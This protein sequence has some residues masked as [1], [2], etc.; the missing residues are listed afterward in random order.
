MPAGAAESAAADSRG[1]RPGPPAR[2]EDPSTAL[3]AGGAPTGGR[4]ARQQAGERRTLIVTIPRVSWSEL[5]EADMPNLHWLM[6]QGAVGLMPV[7]KPSDADPDRTWVTL[8]A[9]RAAVSSPDMGV[10]RPWDRGGMKIDIARLAEANRRAHT[11][12]VPSMMGEMI[13][14]FI[15]ATAVI[16]ADPASRASC[17]GLAVLADVRGG[18]DG[19]VVGGQLLSEG[20][21]G[22]ALDRRRV[23]AAVRDA[24]AHY[25]VILLDLSD[26][27]R[28]DAA[29]SPTANRP[30]SGPKSAALRATDA[31]IGDAV[32]A[33][34]GHRTLVAILSPVCPNYTRAFPP[35]NARLRDPEARTLGPMVLCEASRGGAISS[36]RESMADAPADLA[37]ISAKPGRS[38]LLTSA[39]TRCPGLVTAADLVPTLARWW[40]VY[41]IGGEPELRPSRGTLAGA[42]GGHALSVVPASDSLSRLD[43]LDRVLA[44]RYRLRVPM[45]KWYVAYALFVLAAGLGLAG[46]G[47]AWLRIGGAKVLGLAFVPVGLA[48]AAPVPP[49]HDAAYLIVAL[50]AA[51]AIALIA[52]GQETRSCPT[53]LAVAML[54][55]S[56]IIVSDVLAG[57]PLMRKSALEMGVMMGSRFYGIGNEYMGSLVGMTTI[58]LGALLQV[59]PQAGRVCALLGVFVA[60]AIGAP[61]WGANWGG[62]LT[63]AVGLATLWLLCLPRVRPRHLA[64]VAALLLASVALPPLLDLVRPAAERS[65]IGAAVSALLAGQAGELSDTILRKAGIARHVI[66]AAPWCAPG[67]LLCALVFWLQLRPGAPARRALSGQRALSAGIAASLIAGVVAMFVNDSGP[68]AGF[69]AILAALATVVFLAARAPEAAA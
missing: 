7:A 11:G 61:F 48:I 6:E 5:R 1:L 68:A 24:V 27:A 39:S 25:R 62:S 10:P 45:A 47:R 21:G 4:L 41:V 44:D 49:G 33:L 28:A 8:A 26:P 29:R 52:H 42:I 12:A 40:G 31:M 9:G 15:G 46:R 51:G 69:G 59:R 36:P 3:R 20:K 13:Q 19:G 60:L 17:R 18:V 57:S 16:G 14:M 64:A 67:A 55:G 50:L 65:H 23:S 32:K 38:G 43:Q 35:G 22:V 53:G 66:R 58:G 56:G 54:L 30:L 63:A 2:P 34:K 37:A